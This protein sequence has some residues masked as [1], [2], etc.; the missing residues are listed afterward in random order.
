[1]FSCHKHG[2]KCLDN[3]L[4]TQGCTAMNMTSNVRTSHVKNITLCRHKHNWKC[5]NIS[6]KI[7]SC[8][9][10]DNISSGF[11]Q[12]WKRCFKHCHSLGSLL[13]WLE[14]HLQTWKSAHTHVMWMWYDTYSRNKNTVQMTHANLNECFQKRKLSIFIL[15]TGCSDLFNRK[16]VT[17]LNA[18]T[19]K[20]Q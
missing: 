10:T 8:V 14:L 17:K 20:W 13:M 12:K 18:F 15:A 3:L 5:P 16:S 6:S 4:K 1:M 7:A 9:A 19:T 11:T 2:R